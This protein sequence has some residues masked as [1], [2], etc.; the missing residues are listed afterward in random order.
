[1]GG[2]KAAASSVPCKVS[3]WRNPKDK[4]GKDRNST[5]SYHQQREQDRQD[6]GRS[7]YDGPDQELA[8]QLER[9]AIHPPPPPPHTHTAFP[10]TATTAVQSDL[11][12][13]YDVR[14][15][16]Y[17][18]CRPELA[19]HLEREAVILRS[20]SA[21]LLPDQQA[22]PAIAQ[23]NHTPMISTLTFTPRDTP[24]LPITFHTR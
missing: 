11:A 4:P 23:S 18:R 8:A 2:S 10:F 15:S 24:P 20:L 21:L 14:G 17:N 22:L 13:L 9:S 1:L 5:S 19:A 6:T 16:G 12:F 3:A 7:R